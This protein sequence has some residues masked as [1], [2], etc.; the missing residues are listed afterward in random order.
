GHTIEATAIDIEQLVAVFERLYPFEPDPFQREAIAALA[1]GRSVLVTAPT[2]TGKTLVAEFAVWNALRNGRSAIYTTPIKAL[3]NQKFRDL[4]A[5]YGHD[6][7]GLL[8]GDIVENPGARVRVMTTEVLRNMLLQDAS[9]VASVGAVIFDEIHYLADS[10]RGTTWEEALIESPPEVQLVCLSAT[11]G[12]AE[13]LAEWLSS[14]RKPGDLVHVNWTRRAVPLENRYLLD[15]KLIPFLSPDGQVLRRLHVGGELAR[16]VGIR[17]LPSP[18]GRPR[19]EVH[20]IPSPPEVLRLLAEHELLPAIYFLF[21]RRATE[22]AAEQC[23]GWGRMPD[24]D[25]IYQRLEHGLEGLSEADRGIGQVQ[26]LRRLL[27]RGIGFHHA[28]MLPTLKIVVEDLLAAGQLRAV[29]ATDTLS[30]GINA[31]ARAVVLGDLTKYDGVSRRLLAASEYRQLTG[32]AGR[33]GLDDRGVAVVLYSP[34]VEFAQVLRMANGPLEPLE[35]AFRPGYSTAANIWLQGDAER[36]LVR[37]TGMSLRRF[38]RQGEV[39]RLV[40]ERDEIRT[41]LDTVVG[42]PL[43]DGRPRKCVR[44]LSAALASADAEL[45]RA[46]GEA[47]TAGRRMIRALRAVLERYG[48]LR[49]GLPEPAIDR[50]AH[51]FDTNAL[52]LSELVG[53]GWLRGLLP[54]ELAEVAAWFAHDKEGAER[55][56]PMPSYL[57]RLRERVFGLHLE[58]LGVE[59]RH[60]LALSRPL[61]LDLAGLA[62]AWAKGAT[63]EECTR[64]GRLGEGDFV[65]LVQKTI[66][67]MGQLREAAIHEGGAANVEVA[68]RLADGARMLRRGVIAQTYAVVVGEPELATEIEGNGD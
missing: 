61:S 9:A 62:L 40:E 37:L 15:N 6:S 21:S 54:E 12:N 34:W 59:R 3:S 47:G 17:G 16:H 25:A 30:L 29:F 55:P 4:R 8:T 66:D 2:A 46:Q 35:S 58:V 33:R 53:R 28:G 5:L 49:N 10:E 31:P 67:L 1:E 57:V 20:P 23:G 48:Y 26:L 45:E 19:G 38:Q 60:D 24:A 18:R 42:D 22:Q 41:E 44:T 27:P 64:R 52:T 68:G 32:R 63:L 51:I 14:L 43:R 50:L 65:L 39:A 7:V 56:L 36:R 11:V 13:Q